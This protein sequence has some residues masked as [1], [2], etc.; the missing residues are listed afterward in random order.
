MRW[1]LTGIWTTVV[2]EKDQELLPAWLTAVIII[3]ATHHHP[4]PDAVVFT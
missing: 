3:I 1:V 2:G 4:L